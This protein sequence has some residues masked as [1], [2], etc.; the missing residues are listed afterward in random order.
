MAWAGLMTNASGNLVARNYANQ[1]V[2]LNNS[3]YGGTQVNSGSNG[4]VTNPYGINVTV[5]STREWNGSG[6]E[7]PQ[8]TLK[9]G[10]SYDFQ[11][12]RYSDPSLHPS[13]AARLNAQSNLRAT[14]AAGLS[15][16]GRNSARES[17]GVLATLDQQYFGS[18]N[19]AQTI[20]TSQPLSQVAQANAAGLATSNRRTIL[21]TK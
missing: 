17:P 21:G 9:G 15:A 10:Q 14:Q 3:Y 1:S 4:I 8:I 20:N 19:V 16:A 12:G 5:G 6:S 7:G 18:Q 11:Y 2:M 13:T